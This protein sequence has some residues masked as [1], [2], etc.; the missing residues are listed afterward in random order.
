MKKKQIGMKERKQT[1]ILKKKERKKKASNKKT[2][3]EKNKKIVRTMMIAS[4]ANI[5]TSPLPNQNYNIP[6][7]ALGG[8]QK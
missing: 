4:R 1:G 5:D 8:I 3:K 6:F 7:Y 2:N